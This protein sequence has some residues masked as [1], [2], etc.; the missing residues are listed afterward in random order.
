MVKHFSKFA[1]LVFLLPGPGSAEIVAS[2]DRYQIEANESFTLTVTIDKS[3]SEPPDLAPLLEDFDILNNMQRA[4]TQIVNG[5]IQQSRSFVFVL[6]PKRQGALT[7]PSLTAAGESTRPIEIKVV[8]TPLND[9]AGEDVFITAELDRAQTWVQ[10][11]S[12][13]RVRIYTAVSTR[14]PQLSEPEVSGADVILQRMGDD[15]RYS[16]VIEGRGYEVVERSYAVFPQQSGQVEIGSLVFSARIW[17][18]SRL[19]SRKIFKSEPLGLTVLP[20]PPAPREYTDAAWLP[21]ENVELSDRWNP[22]D[23]SIDAGEPI[24]RTIEVK[25]TGLLASQLQALPEVQTD[26][27]RIYADQPELETT[28]IASGMVGYRTER[29]AVIASRP[30]SYTLPAVKLPWWNVDQG[31]WQIASLPEVSLEIGSASVL[32][33]EAG[34][35]ALANSS[36]SDGIS[37]DVSLAGARFWPMISLA[38]ALLW[39]A[40]L[41]LWWASRRSSVATQVKNNPQTPAYR[42]QRRLAKEARSAALVGN[43]RLLAE[44]LIAWGRIEFPDEQPGNLGALASLCTDPLAS[45]IGGLNAALYSSAPARISDAELADA[46]SHMTRLPAKKTA[47]TTEVL[48]TLAP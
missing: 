9:D 28:R 3:M 26:G 33:D 29:F 45:A 23:L 25:A 14:Q 36:E 48:A 22:S 2:V 20:I 12:V 13:L 34:S 11:Q 32:D 44:K 7:I 27:L 42:H 10:A 43:H 37:T 17:E 4:Q 18:R 24:S 35:N 1:L 46:L 15:A 38:L 5:Q 19:S 8:E 40:T 16:A 41:A 31:E 47:R 21:A 39:F 30:G 6:M